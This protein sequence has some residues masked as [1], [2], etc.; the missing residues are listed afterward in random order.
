MQ[1]RLESV[2]VIGRKIGLN[3]EKGV[4]VAVF[5]ALIIVA[6]TVA[7]YYY[8]YGP[9]PEPYNSINLLDAN[10]KAVDY[11]SVLVA[12]QNST[13]SLYMQV[14]NHMNQDLSYQVRIKITQNLPASIPNGV[15]VEPVSVVDLI[16]KNGETQQSLVTVTENEVGHYSV[17]FE[18]WQQDTSGNFVFTQDYCVLNIQVIN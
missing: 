10:A 4:V 15:Q 7:V 16:V 8:V 2:T 18:L 5:V 11:P 1:R 9:K 12:N 13:F 6:C 3:D 17:V 14:G